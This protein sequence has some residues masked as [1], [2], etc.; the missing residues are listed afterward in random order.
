MAIVRDVARALNSQWDSV[1]MNNS[2]KHELTIR[3]TAAKAIG[4]VSFRVID[5]FAL[6]HLKAANLFRDQVVRIERE[7]LGTELGAFFDDI[8]SYSSGCILSSVASVE[9]LINEEF[10]AHGSPLRAACADFDAEFWGLPKV[11]GTPI[12]RKPILEKYD[13]ALAKLGFAKLAE[14][15]AGYQ[16]MQALVELRNALTHFKPEWD[17]GKIRYLQPVS[18]QAFALSP[19]LDEG[20]GFLMKCMSAGCCEWAVMSARSFMIEFLERT[21]LSPKR[22]NTLRNLR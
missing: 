2:T 9:G 7:N 6:Q 8:R 5:N 20:A 14:A 4:S 16:A 15:N 17:E 18:R 19:F 3:A 1:E 10:I 13:I 12:E 21:S 22:L 11:K